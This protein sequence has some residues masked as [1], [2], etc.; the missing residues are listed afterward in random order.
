MGLTQYIADHIT[1]FIQMTGYLSVFIFMMMESMVLPVPSEAIMPFA[2]FLIV[3][4]RFS[5][6]MVILVSTS[7][8]IVGSYISY[9]LGKYG[10]EPFFERYGKY[11][12]VNKRHL[13]QTH[14]FFNRYGSYTIFISRFIPVIRHL[15][16][17]PAGMSRMKL[18]RFL[19]FTAL[20]AALWNTF[21]AYMGY[22]LKQNW[23]EI[24]KYSHYI[25]ISVIVAFVLVIAFFVWQQIKTKK[26]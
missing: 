5:W 7:G 14:R 11:L 13:E 6:E 8:S 24:M 3:Q 17:V 19:L 12:L 26:V 21:L 2:G 23:D 18:T 25:D 15:I 1:E 22:I 9:L 16:S 20:G 10:G 4:G